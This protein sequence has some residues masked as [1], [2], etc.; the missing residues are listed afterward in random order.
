LANIAAIP[1][2]LASMPRDRRGYPIPV[3]AARD[4]KG[5]PLYVVTDFHARERMVAEDRCHLS[6]RKLFRGRWF[7]GGPMA[8]F[9]EHGAFLDGPMLD[10]ASLFAVRT[11]P[12]IAAPNYSKRVDELIADR[13]VK[14]GA[15]MTVRM[16]EKAVE[17]RPVLFARV[18][19]V[20]NR[21]VPSDTGAPI[22][23]PKKPYRKVEFWRHGVLLDFREGLAMAV[24]SADGHLTE[25]DILAACGLTA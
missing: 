21:I 22:F 3:T 9:H 6:G 7:I 4:A 11:C 24:E 12:F 2:C 16:E 17:D 8:A 15:A 19:T 5:N 10:E 14:D 1:E 18:M 25:R 13:A 20:G 23:V